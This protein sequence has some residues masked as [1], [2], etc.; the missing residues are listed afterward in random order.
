MKKYLIFWG[1]I[2]LFFLFTKLSFC[3]P[4]TQ[5]P[6]I[7][8]EL[9]LN[10]SQ[11]FLKGSTFIELP[12]KKY[13]KLKVKN[14]G[15]KKV[16]LDHTSLPSSTNDDFLKIITG[17]ES[18]NLYIEFETHLNLWSSPF[19]LVENFLPLPEGPL[20][21]TI[22]IKIEPPLETWEVLIPYDEVKKTTEDSWLSYTFSVN[23]PIIQ[24]T[25]ILG[26]FKKESLLLERVN[27][28]IFYFN[29]SFKKAL[30]SK[31][32]LFKN[33]FS[34]YEKLIGSFPFKNIFILENP[35]S[36]S[37]D[38]PYFLFLDDEEIKKE[39]WEY[40]LIKKWITNFLFW[41]VGLTEKKLVKGLTEYLVDYQFS[42]SKAFFRKQYLYFP[43]E[44]GVG[45]FYILNLAE[46]LGE[47]NFLSMLKKFL[48]SSSYPKTLEDFQN[49]FSSY[50]FNLFH[51]IDLNG[52]VNFLIENK[53]GYLLEL[54]L[55]QKPPFRS[56]KLTIKIETEKGW[57]TFQ[58]KMHNL[59]ETVEL[60]LK[61]KPIAIYL[62]PEYKLWRKLTGEEIEPTLN[63]LIN[64]PGVLVCSEKNLVLYQKLIHFFRER[65]YKLILTDTHLPVEAFKETVIYF[66]ETPFQQLKEPSFK[67]GFYF[68]ITPHPYV[69]QHLVGYFWT[70]SLKEVDLFLNQFSSLNLFREALLKKG[71]IIFSQKVEPYHGI[72]IPVKNNYW[73]I[74]L[75]SVLSLDQLFQKLTDTQIILVGINFS[76]FSNYDFLNKFLNQLSSFSFPVIIGL[77]ELPQ[78]FQKNLEDFMKNRLSENS[79]KEKLSDFPY[80]KFNEK[81]ILWAKNH[82]IK[83]LA[84]DVE[85][86]LF[87]KVWKGGLKELTTEEKLKLPE[88]DLFNPPYKSYLESSLWQS[89]KGIPFE[90]FYQAEVL[91]NEHLA[92]YLIEILKNNP[93]Y[94]LILLA[95]KHRIIYGWGIPKN[96]QKR[97]WE[98]F[99]IIILDRNIFDQPNIGDFWI[100]LE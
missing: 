17:E 3:F 78:S 6:Y 53:E 23:S 11:G 79:I 80:K 64:S 87:K 98:N 63:T 58:V 70:S 26:K 93:H 55:I 20:L 22:S 91:K 5:Y 72:K 56:E 73:V 49:F 35:Y 90:N 1:I 50:P 33:L 7:K 97:G 82:N 88:I 100:K 29:T 92:E 15:L 13:Y 94:K 74:D 10:P 31:S 43:D 51:K 41:K 12:P 48:N 36:S 18:K 46:R 81:V 76:E 69:P 16:F 99:K 65:G 59:K 62:D 28:Q 44:E 66:Q 32:T 86:D 52:K 42:S 84:M 38:I 21:Y 71:K 14:L 34:Y 9:I 4:E 95:E 77:G 39:N 57:E 68:K 45:F 61:E 83:V 37:K 47:N 27:L 75:T 54:Q 89:F 24:P 96:L 2:F 8:A 85:E 25:L 67:D 40:L 19:I 30:E 60:K